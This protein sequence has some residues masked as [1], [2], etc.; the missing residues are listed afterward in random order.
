MT[1]PH[2][3]GHALASRSASGRARRLRASEPRRTSRIPCIRGTGGFPWNG[4]NGMMERLQQDTDR[5][6]RTSSAKRKSGCRVELA[7]AAQTSSLTR[8]VLVDHRRKGA[9]QDLDVHP[10][11]PLLDILAIQ[12]NPLL[13]GQ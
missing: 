7:A 5:C 13:V 1:R 8:A 10:E 11:R 2:A 9:E 4:F 3:T 6:R 12:R